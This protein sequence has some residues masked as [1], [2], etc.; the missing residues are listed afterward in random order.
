MSR[1]S[2]LLRREHLVKHTGFSLRSVGLVVAFL[3]CAFPIVSF[4][5]DDPEPGGEG[6]DEMV[7]NAKWVTSLGHITVEHDRK[8]LTVKSSGPLGTFEHQWSPPLDLDIS[9]AMPKDNDPRFVFILLDD[10]SIYDML[11]LPDGSSSTAFRS[12]G[13]EPLNKLVGDALYGISSSSVYLS[14]DSAATFQV[15]TVG[16]GSGYPYDIGLDTLQYVYLAT[17]AG[18]L[19]QHPDTSIWRKVTS[20]PVSFTNAV[21]VDR[22]NRIIVASSRKAYLST[23][24][25]STWNIDTTGLNVTDILGLKGF[26]DDAFGN[27]YARSATELWRSTGGTQPWTHIDQPL[28][29]LAYD[30]SVYPLFNSLSGDTLLYAAT[31]FGSFVSSDQ[32]AT[33]SQYGTPRRA[34]FTY[35]FV[36][37]SSGRRL[38]S[39]SL[40]IFY[41][42]VGDLQWTKT[43]PTTGYLA[44][45][46]VFLDGSGNAYTLGKKVSS[47]AF[48]DV[49][50]NWK[51]TDGGLTWNADTAGLGSS[52]TGQLPLYF[53]D[54][55][56]TQHYGA[57]GSPANLY[58]KAAGQSWGPD[59][60]GYG[61][62]PSEYPIAFGTDHHGFAY[63]ATNSLSTYKGMV[64][65]RPV[66]GGT[67]IP[68]TAGLAGTQVYWITADKNGVPLAGAIDGLYRKNGATWTKLPSPSGL[69]GYSAFVVSVDSSGNTIAGFSTYGFPNYLWRGL[70][71]TNNNGATWSYLGLDSISVRGLV[72]YGDT[73]YAYT[74]A[75]GLY[76]VRSTGGASSVGVTTQ[77]TSY[78]LE[79]N[80]PNPFNPTTTIRFSLGQRGRVSL[81][82]FDILGREVA[83][84]LNGE[85]DAGLH[86]AT[87]DASKLASGIYLYR[88]RAG[89]FME[90]KKL[91]L[92]K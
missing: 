57:Y 78:R 24:G 63:V 9:Y 27:I 21:F 23:N 80:Y 10:G 15:D 76:K 91:L 53:V 7:A 72:S 4:A 22:K 89:E 56:G 26:C 44:A 62:R 65:K 87:F 5:Q 77:P 82:I 48:C 12:K 85:L 6:T 1:F 40:G 69:N 70:Y 79:Q 74:Y 39:T 11:L 13:T 75:D 51:S 31:V 2:S 42:S 54:E 55:T 90:T 32:G 28:S 92:L 14:R 67:W 38:A 30:P 41:K 60:S 83:T 61:I 18:L 16:L 8:V 58:R 43:F 25:G 66:A 20:F 73:T 45:S 81:K 34:Q 19:R 52:G 84:L 59:T 33:W 36:R 88:V 68:D 35:G 37:T 47:V 3:L 64:W 46:P 50:A 17:S 71:A 29:A 49:R 86:Q